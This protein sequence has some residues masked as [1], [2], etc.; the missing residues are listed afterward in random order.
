MKKIRNIGRC[1][2]IMVMGFAVMACGPGDPIGTSAQT[3]TPEATI[4]ERE[5]ITEEPYTQED[6][7]K[8]TE[9][10][11]DV[12]QTQIDTSG[13]G[14]PLEEMSGDWNGDGG[15]DQLLI[16]QEELEGSTYT[17]GI[18]LKISG[19]KPYIFQTP[20]ANTYEDFLRGDFD[21]DGEVEYGIVIDLQAQ[22]ANGGYGMVLV[23]YVDGQW[24]EITQQEPFLFTGF[25]YEVISDEGGWYH[26]IGQES[27][28]EHMVQ[29]EE[30]PET[31]GGLVTP[32]WLWAVIDGEDQDYLQIW[33][34]AAGGH[35]VN[36]ICDVVA[37]FGVKDGRLEII[38]EYVSQDLM[39]YDGYEAKILGWNHS[40]AELTGEYYV[41]LVNPAGMI[42]ECAPEHENYEELKKYERVWVPFST[43]SVEFFSTGIE[44]AIELQVLCSYE[45]FLQDWDSEQLY[46]ITFYA[47]RE[48][49]TIMRAKPVESQSMSQT[50]RESNWYHV[51]MMDKQLEILPI[52]YV[53]ENDTKRLDELV[54][55]GWE[56][57]KLFFDE[58]FRKYLVEYETERKI[59]YLTENTRYYLIDAYG[60]VRAA[61][62]EMY[63]RQDDIHKSGDYRIILE[64]DQVICVLLD[65]RQ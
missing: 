27:G 2:L 44:P 4:Q 18:Q 15:H 9:M 56:L 33:Q 40:M 37:T 22:G 60:Y 12:E 24:V 64:Q 39:M 26:I 55:Q 21:G 13:W 34:Y 49:A 32:F 52:E 54:Q 11:P 38:E 29:G 59:V 65:Q 16:Y 61:E 17:I 19:R 30:I 53:N 51:L 63:F 45:E 43:Q 8:E 6:P 5:D 28:L 48:R 35:K 20:G 3:E 36:Q 31:D 23:D 1:I 10:L 41:R 62:N 42:L 57:D 7:Q 46:E 58:M 47:V 25:T 14:Q 50:Q